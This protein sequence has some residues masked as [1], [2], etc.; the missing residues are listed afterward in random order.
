MI[1][2]LSGIFVHKEPTYVILDVAGV[3][4]G[5]HISL[6]TFEAIKSLDDCTLLTLMQV[7]NEASSLYGFYTLE[8]KLWFLHLIGVTSIG[9]KIALTILSSLTPGGIHKA[10]LGKDLHLLTSIKGVGAKAAQRLMLELSDKAQKFDGIQDVVLPKPIAGKI[11]QDAIT[12][13][14]TLG[15]TQ[16]LAEKAV[17]AVRAQV[18]IPLTL[19]ELIKKALQP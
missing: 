1:A 17:A 4:Y 9:P 19:E 2:Q 10:I 3:G 15:L 5:L 11:D 18:S 13:L 6:Y 8:E 7:K 14:T 16:K 12:A